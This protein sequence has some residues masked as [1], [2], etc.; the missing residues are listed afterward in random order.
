M[1]FLSFAF[2]ASLSH[3]CCY[4]SDSRVLPS[5]DGQAKAFLMSLKIIGKVI[6]TYKKSLDALY[7][8][9][10][11]RE[12]N[13]DPLTQKEFTKGQKIRLIY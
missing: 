11:K 8:K 6:L 4:K 7:L 1:L 13:E 9:K 2:C 3:F 12:V 10:I 5:L